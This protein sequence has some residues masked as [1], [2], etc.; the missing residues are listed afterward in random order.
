MNGRELAERLHAGN[1]DLLVIFMSGYTDEILD[2]E[3]LVGPGALFVAKPFTPAALVRHVDQLLSR[4]R[5]RSEA[6]R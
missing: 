2:R 4:Q 5:Q 6:A 1:P 3:A